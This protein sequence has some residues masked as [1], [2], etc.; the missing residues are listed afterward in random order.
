MSAKRIGTK[1]DGVRIIIDENIKPDI[2]IYYYPYYIRQNTNDFDT[3]DSDYLVELSNQ[4]YKIEVYEAYSRPLSDWPEIVDIVL[5][6][7]SLRILEGFFTDIGSD[8]YTKIKTKLKNIAPI[9]KDRRGKEVR[10]GIHIC[11]TQ[12]IENREVNIKVA[13][14]IDDLDNLNTEPFTLQTI[15][16]FISDI[17][18][19]IDFKEVLVAKTNEFPFWKVISYYDKNGKYVRIR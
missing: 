6:F 12:L 10:T 16:K 8:I 11:Y 7:I 17:F 15:N 19:D 4:D 9:W 2:S 5:T 18:D 3:K 1:L 13:I 14:K